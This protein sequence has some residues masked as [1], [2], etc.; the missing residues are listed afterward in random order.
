MQ[1]AAISYD[2]GSSKLDVWLEGSAGYEFNAGA[3]IYVDTFVGWGKWKRKVESLS[4]D[5]INK[6]YGNSDSTGIKKLTKPFYCKNTI[7]LNV[8]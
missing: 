4:K 5:L 1:Y 3:R 6:N 8:I 7:S 2:V